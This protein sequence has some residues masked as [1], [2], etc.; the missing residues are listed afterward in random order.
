M[1]SEQELALAARIEHVSNLIGEDGAGCSSYN[2]KL[3]VGPELLLQ[4]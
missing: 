3:A 2:L 1:M 4:M